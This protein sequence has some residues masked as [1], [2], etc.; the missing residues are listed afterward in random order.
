MLLSLLR[1]L[2]GVALLGYASW[3]DWRTR[4]VGNAL[5][6]LMAGLGLA[7]LAGEF[8]LGQGDPLAALVVLPLGLLVVDLLWDREDNPLQR[9]LTLLLYGVAAGTVLLLLVLFD[10]FGPTDR[11]LLRR[12]FG[13]VVVVLLAYAFY[14]VGLFRG[15]ADA[16]AFL[17]IG[18][19]VPGY[20][21]AGP[22]PLVPIPS[23]LLPAFELLFPFAMSALM[24]A[25]L[26]LLALPVAFLVRNLWRG[27]YHWPQVLTGYKAPLDALPRFAWVLQD[28]EGGRVR[29]D[30][31]ARKEPAEVDVEGL[32]Q[33]GIDRVWITPQVPFLLP[34]A[35]GFV[36][37]FLVGNLLLALL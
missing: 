13:A 3:Q 21:A 18:I 22:F 30:I 34:L 20:P 27:D 17:C 10:R 7:L 2:A 9:R 6:A 35:A 36:I 15:G 24:N 1:I 33:L 12:A 23:L 19:L 31:L 14:H 26:L 28:V 32:R 8:V 29:Y 25:A 5:W 16:K 37:T 4:E 11:D